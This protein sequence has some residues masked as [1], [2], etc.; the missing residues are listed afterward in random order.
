MVLATGAYN[1]SMAG[2]YNRVG[3][4]AMV[5]V[6]NGTPTL[7]LKRESNEDLVQNDVVM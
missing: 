2:N 7:I 1:Y 3:R 5:L 4:P 6:N